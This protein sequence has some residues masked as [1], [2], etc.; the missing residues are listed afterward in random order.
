[1]VVPYEAE[2]VGGGVMVFAPVPPGACP[3]CAVEHPPEEPHWLTI[4]YIYRFFW[5]HGRVPTWDDAM[6]HCS[7]EVQEAWLVRCYINSEGSEGVI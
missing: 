4:Y 3:L 7:L 2:T 1:M 5:D 6:A